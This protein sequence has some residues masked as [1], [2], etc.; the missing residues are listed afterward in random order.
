M[1]V[2]FA[3][4]SPVRYRR[5]SPLRRDPENCKL[6]DSVLQSIIPFHKTYPLWKGVAVRNRRVPVLAAIMIA[7]FCA[8]SHAGDLKA[9]PPAVPADASRSK[10]ER[11]VDTNK[12]TVLDSKTE[13]MW[14]T[15][16]NIDKAPMP[17]QMA[18]Q[19][20]QD[21]NNGLRQNFG[22]TNWRL[23]TIIDFESL[24]DKTRKNPSLPE[25]HPFKNIQSDLYWSSSQGV[26]D[27]M[28]YA[29]AVSFSSGEVTTVYTSSCTL[30]Y[31]WPVR[32]TWK[33]LKTRAGAV[34]IGGLNTYG[35]LGDGT[36]NDRTT[37]S[38]VT[39]LNDFVAVATGNGHTLAVRIDGTIWAWGDNSELQLGSE[40]IANN[41]VPAMVRGVWKI[42]DAAAG[43]EHSV[44]LS[45]DGTVWTWGRNSYGQLG[46]GTNEDRSA[47]V[48]VKDLSHVVKVA[49]G[50]Y[51]T[52]AL[53]SDGTVWA[54]GMNSNGQ[55]GNDLTTHRSIPVQVNN[56]SKIV[57]VSANL[58]HSLALTANGAVWSWG[59]NSYGLLG[60]GSR[61]DK[62]LPVPV[63]G[64]SNITAISA[65]LDHSVALKSDGTVWTWG[66]NEYSQLGISA[67]VAESSP[68]MVE[69]LSG[70]K[71]ISAGMYHSVAVLSDGTI[72][73]WGKN[74]E[75]G[76]AKSRPYNNK[77]VK[78]A[79]DAA[80]GKYITIILNAADA[81]KK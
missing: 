59:K 14:L 53:K 37:L 12:G 52:L 62:H 35:Q 26:D 70:V 1:H 39:G 57:D 15:D 27:I 66:G 73:V 67:V 45:A 25:A 44:A 8:P 50:A 56:L 79:F 74:L 61:D 6:R 77:Y 63:R 81:R 18:Q 22:F 24:L 21:M 71:K 58:N 64:I 51:H 68:V 48:E 69:D 41:P 28:E 42:V 3:G 43:Y 29:E 55:L 13:Q 20:I 47:P 7:A 31:F 40:S 36:T 4:Q 60:D 65:G 34:L 33:A 38:P 78:D 10:P 17:M 19:K 16:A 46:D 72:S 80:A 49:A 9:A 23:P 32:S 75:K 76:L 5:Q 11:F 30:K 2:E 54:W